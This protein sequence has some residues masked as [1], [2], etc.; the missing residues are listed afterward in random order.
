MHRHVAAGVARVVFGASIIEAVGPRPRLFQECRHATVVAGASNRSP[1][2]FGCRLISVRGA[3]ALCG[4][5]GAPPSAG[6]RQQRG[7]EG[8]EL[9][10]AREVPD[11]AC[12]R[13]IVRAEVQV[14]RFDRGPMG[15]RCSRQGV[16]F[17]IV[18]RCNGVT[19]RF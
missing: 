6:G 15:S 17:W 7:A 3:A 2:N 12:V 18:G 8:H 5:C 9:R 16:D 1:D 4:A 10:R 13:M 19:L 14:C 11:N